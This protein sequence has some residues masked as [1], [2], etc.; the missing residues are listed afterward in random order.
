MSKKEQTARSWS[1][2]KREAVASGLI[3]QERL[4]AAKDRAI[5]DVRAYRLAEVR[6]EQATTQRELAEIM[7]VSQGRV[8]QIESG[9]IATF[10]LGTLRSYVEAM[11]GSLRVVAQFGD[12]ELTI[13]D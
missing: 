3:T 11:G 6:K 10:E 1:E 8:S 9:R 13:S 7:H 2:V 5:A 4:D 12:R